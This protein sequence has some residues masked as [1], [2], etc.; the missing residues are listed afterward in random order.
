MKCVHRQ[1]GLL[2]C[3]VGCVLALGSAW[4]QDAIYRCGNVYTNNPTPLEKKECNVIDGGNV[5]VIQGFKKGAQISAPVPK[6]SADQAVSAPRVASSG[7]SFDQPK[8]DAAQQ[9]QRDSDARAILETE[10]R[11]A[12]TKLSDLQKEYNEGQPDRKGDEFRNGGKYMDRIAELKTQVSR[13]E[14]DVT[15]IR[16]ELARIAPSASSLVSR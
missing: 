2:A 16:R 13:A 1:I 3:V 5:T 4:A 6:K 7:A 11:R 15:S 8:V 14:A 9:K 12:E 10:L